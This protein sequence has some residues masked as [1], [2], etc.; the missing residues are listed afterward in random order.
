LKK[1]III[2]IT[3]I[4]AA[5]ILI[6]ATIFSIYKFSVINP[7]SSC[8]GMFQILSGDKEYT[9]VQNYPHKVVFSKPDVRLLDE[10]MKKRGFEL[11]PEWRT[12]GGCF[13]IC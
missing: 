9:I 3:I 8:F 11:S 6:S 12:N 2:Y 1:R 7:F 10:Y 13:Y 4:I 5:A